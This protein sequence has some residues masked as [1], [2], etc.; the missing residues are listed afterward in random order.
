MVDLDAL[1]DALKAG[2]LRGA[3]VDVAEPLGGFTAF[4]YTCYS[5]QPKCA[6]ALVRAAR[7]R[8]ESRGGHTR[9]DY[10]GPSDEMGRVNMIV[11]YADGEVGVTP[12][13]LAEL[14]A[15]LAALLE[16]G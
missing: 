13:P 12:E 4:H 16:E 9:D 6:E 8:T 1:A 7:E 10:P 14:P 11:R 2:K 5:N 3:A 15:E